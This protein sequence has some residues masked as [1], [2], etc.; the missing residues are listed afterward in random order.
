MRTAKL[1]YAR[2]PGEFSMSPVTRPLARLLACWLL[3]T[4]VGCATLHIPQLDLRS[5]KATARNPVAKV[6]CLW[7]PAEGRDPKGNPCHGFAG[8]ILFLNSSS[9][10]VSV[11][12]DVRVYLFDDQGT[13]EE[14]SEPL[15]KFDFDNGAWS[16]HYTY[17]TLGP[18]YNVF[19]PYMRHGTYEATCALRL[20][21]TPK[22]GP[23]VFSEMAS[24]ELMSF[25]GGTKPVSKKPQ[26]DSRV[27]AATAEDLTSV[28]KRRRTTTISLNPN[29]ASETPANGDHDNEIQLAGYEA[30]PRPLTSNDAKIAQ[31]EQMVKE[32]REQQRTQVSPVK[33]AVPAA[34][35]SPP[36]R[37]LEE[38]IDEPSRGRLKSSPTLERASAEKAE[39]SASTDSVRRQVKPKVSPQRHLLEDDEPADVSSTTS[40]PHP[41]LDDES[42]APRRVTRISSQSAHH[43]LEDALDDE[44]PPVR[45]RTATRKVIPPEAS[46]S[47]QDHSISVDPFDP[48][49]ID[50]IE[51]TAVDERQ[52]TRR[53]LRAVNH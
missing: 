40:K 9:L 8:Q 46:S 6:V 30:E 11:D 29:G 19:I 49:D 52:I 35:P 28:N 24:I 33:Q 27:E 37:R 31:L 14:Q 38:V 17:G 50:T 32:L 3:L 48:I 13:V 36:P 43:P 41:L 23:A 20:R 5:R 42:P 26:V 51:T 53:Q 21:L 2:N 44:R 45:E 12:G 1:T 10:P 7:E 39:P 22:Q 18:A 4:T 47:G 15:H 16:Q 25:H 34:V